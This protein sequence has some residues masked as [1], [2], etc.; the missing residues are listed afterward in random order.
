M[1]IRDSRETVLEEEHVDQILE[2]G[3]KTILLHKE[4]LSGIDFSI[5]YLS[6][7]HIYYQFDVVF[8]ALAAQGSGLLCVKRR[9]VGDI[10]VRISLEPVSYTHLV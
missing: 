5:I 8:E 3:A 2:S 9:D 6:L 7:I 1:C 10:E 4:S